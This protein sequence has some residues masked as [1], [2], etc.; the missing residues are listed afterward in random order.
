MALIQ[1]TERTLN[2]IRKADALPG[3]MET[4]A[5][6][7]KEKA[8]SFVSIS[9]M[10]RPDNIWVAP[11]IENGEFCISFV[12]PLK[13]I[14]CSVIVAGTPGPLPGV[15]DLDS[16]AGRVF[17]RNQVLLPRAVTKEIDSLIDELPIEVVYALRLSQDGTPQ[18][19]G[20]VLFIPYSN[21]SEVERGL[22]IEH[23]RKA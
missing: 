7:I 23:L 17:F 4:S 10:K 20:E 3:K 12:P 1:S 14:Y 13:W 5:S 15:A 11:T 6:A 22:F 16:I 2:A 19:D 18:G 9:S 8:G 21:R